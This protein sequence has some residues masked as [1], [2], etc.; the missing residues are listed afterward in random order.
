MEISSHVRIWCLTCYL[1]LGASGA[2]SSAELLEQTENIPDCIESKMGPF[3]DLCFHT[4]R[5]N[6][7]I[8]IDLK[9]KEN[10]A[11]EESVS[12]ILPYNNLRYSGA[13]VQLYYNGVAGKSQWVTFPNP[14]GVYLMPGA[15][16]LPVQKW[17][18]RGL[19]PGKII[20]IVEMIG[21]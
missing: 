5:V 11:N 21:S 16:M 7:I 8:T 10:Y 20:R 3:P 4:S 2:S 19:K 17:I 18:E 13:I 9:I 6:E 12:V 14:G 1:F 15:I